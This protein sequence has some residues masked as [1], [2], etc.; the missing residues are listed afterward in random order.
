MTSASNGR[1]LGELLGYDDPFRRV[2]EEQFGEDDGR[3]PDPVAPIISLRQFVEEAWH[4]LEPDRPFMASWHVDAICEHLEWV[5]ASEILRLVINIPPGHAKS[6]ITSVLWPAWVWSW[7]SGWR[8]LFGSY[9]EK[10]SLRDSVKSRT[11]MQSPWFQERF[12]PR[13]RFTSDQNVKGYYRNS[14]MGERLAISTSSASTGFRGDC[15]AVDDPINALDRHNVNELDR[16]ADWWD[17]VMSSRLNDQRTG[18]RV[19][20]MQRLHGKDLTGHVLAKNTGYVH[21]RL[22]TE[23][24]PKRRCVTRTK[25]GKIWYDRRRAKGEL[26]FPELYPPDVIDQAKVDLGTWDFAAQHDQDPLPESGGIFHRAWFK[27]YTR[28]Q[29]PPVF[30]EHV[31][32]WDF[33]FKKK[34]DTD[35]VVG[36]VW[37]RLGADCFLRFERRGRMGFS[38]SK[39]AV[40]DTSKAWPEATLKLIEDKANGPAI[41]E[42]LRSDIDGIIAVQNN[43][44][45]LAGAWAIQAWCEAGNVWIPDSSEWPEA[46][47]WL[48]EICTYPKAT[49]D[50]RVACLVQA[51]LRL[52]HR[53]GSR[54]GKPD[55]AGKPTEAAAAAKQR[56]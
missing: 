56:F 48:D 18:G 55:P 26:L 1:T 29:L 51:I 53:A 42:D 25:S 40:R 20:M 32:S 3:A 17:K 13:W 31:Q 7:R 38:E 54:A 11:V 33:T 15:I 12:A 50:D 36:Q 45:V 8:S 16:V 19:I 10:L 27:R 35:Y 47:D 24:N 41:I 43:D 4:V 9:D 52:K 37:S 5:T 44:G 34:E 28:A 14:R 30:A 2:Q 23:F 22:P 49:Y 39:R 46:D 6:L 21:L